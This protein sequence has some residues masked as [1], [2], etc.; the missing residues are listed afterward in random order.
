MAGQKGNLYNGSIPAISG[1]APDTTKT[2]AVTVG[3][4]DDGQAPPA[5]VLDSNAVAA[6]GRKFSKL[7][8]T[9]ASERLPVEEK[10]IKNLRQ[11]RGEY[12][13]EILDKL[14]ANRSRAYPR[15]TRVKCISMLSR[16]MNLMFPGNE[17]N[18][19]LNASPSPT[20]NPEA[21]A[22]A[23]SDL[24]ETLQAEGVETEMTQELVDEAVRELANKN[25]A[26]I[27]K[28][29]KDQLNELGGG[30]QSDWIT[31]NRKVCQSGIDYGI[32]A[33][34]GPFVR[35]VQTGGWM[36]EAEGG[37]KPVEKTVYKPMFEFLPVWDLY[38][39]MTARTAPGEGYFKRK[40]LGKRKLRKLAERHEFFAEQVKAVIKQHPNGNYKPKSWETTLQGMGHAQESNAASVN[41]E[42]REKYEV[43]VWMGPVSARD[44]KE[45]GVSIPEDKLSDDIDAELWMV[46]NQV[47]KAVMNPWR[48]LDT[49]M[50]QIHVFVF[51]EDDTSPIGEGLPGIVR[52]SQLAVCAATRMT[53]DNAG[54]VCGPQMEANLS[55]LRA[56]Q[57]LTAIEAYKIW[58][59]DDEDLTAQFP[60]IRQLNID[61]NLPELQS[62]VTMFM[63]FAEME[64]FIGPMTGGD[65]SRMPSEPMRTAA[66][67]SMMR[68]DAALP[69]KDIVRNYDQFT[70]SVLWSM[71]TFN[72]KFNPDETPDGDY[73]VI[74]RGATSLIAKEV[75]GAQLDQLSQTLTPEERDH[76]D[77]R[78]FLEA[79][80]GSRDLQGMMVSE[81][82]VK[83]LRDQRGA[84]QAET[85]ELQK[86]LSEANVREILTEAMKNIAQA[87]KNSS[88]ADQ[89]AI[90]T[91]IDMQ[92][93]EDDGQQQAA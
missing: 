9:Y 69:F 86:R 70:Q 38:V 39:D 37:F 7:F 71:V 6:L 84:K 28:L 27:A 44:L 80:M 16:I 10:W 26:V 75:R 33:I 55:L 60:A 47:I 20:M 51:D 17:D 79:R 85:E 76:I 30:Q 3:E 52:D 81:D 66:G 18:W 14:P 1:M 91:V 4:G 15:L 68:G 62:L 74:P 56:D 67:A 64:T 23:V 48:K 50:D 25:A 90:K 8:D 35:K 12:D 53:L 5:K 63:D 88:T 58:Y 29:L 93:G 46:G 77:E 2:P 24:L 45:V 49:E 40:V 31:L 78:R 43:I 59:R 83:R 87:Q 34:E 54:V 11:K 19:E 21:V 61:G 42:G 92:E 89:A 82:A 36:L 13:P 57:D 65:L 22:D 41:A 32:G 73:D 72:R